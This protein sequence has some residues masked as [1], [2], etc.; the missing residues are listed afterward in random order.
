LG[1]RRIAVAR[2]LTKLHEEV[3]RG[4]ISAATQHFREPRGEFVLVLEGKK[5]SEVTKWTEGQLLGAI[6]KELESGET[7]SALAAKLAD[8]SGW[9]RRDIYALTI[10]QD[11]KRMP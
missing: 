4:T 7:P 6:H 1:D 2:E 3:W 10:K 9:P 8:S 5:R 11:T